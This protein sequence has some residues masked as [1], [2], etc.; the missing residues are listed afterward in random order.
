MK[1]APILVVGDTGSGKSSILEGLPA[2][3]TC[4]LNTENKV[5]PFGNAHEF[6]NVYVS[7]FKTTVEVLKALVAQADPEHPK[8]GTYD[9]VCIDSFTS[10]TEFV[11][12]YCDAV[13]QGFTQWKKYNEHLFEILMLIKQLPQRA[14]VMGIPERQDPNTMDFK[15]Y[16]KVKAKELKF[17]NIEKEFT[18]VMFTKPMYAEEDMPTYTNANGKVLEDVEEGDMIE[19]FLQYK[20]NKKNSAK[21]PVGMFP[22]KVS[23][24]GVAMFKAMEEYYERNNIG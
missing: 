7:N 21:A 5:L 12:R 24:D 22:N 15:Q 8:H 9:Y 2:S 23:N 11:D 1:H 20:A 3:R 13:Y 17:G 16:V 14:I 4:V 19:C 6:K 10:I 18:V